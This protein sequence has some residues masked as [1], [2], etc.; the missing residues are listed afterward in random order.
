MRRAAIFAA[1]AGPF[2]TAVLPFVAYAL[3]GR[4]EQP[5]TLLVLVEDAS[6]SAQASAAMVPQP[7]SGPADSLGVECAGRF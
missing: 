7:A 3:V 2:L 6:S 5:A 4:N 1:L